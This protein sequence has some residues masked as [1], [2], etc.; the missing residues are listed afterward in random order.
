MFVFLVYNYNILFNIY[1]RIHILLCYKIIMFM[2]LVILYLILVPCPCNRETGDEVTRPRTKQ[3]TKLKT[4]VVTAAPTNDN[5]GL[6]DTNERPINSKNGQ[7]Q[8][9]G[10]DKRTKV[11]ETTATAHL[12]YQEHVDTKEPLMEE[13][14]EDIQLIPNP[15]AR[16]LLLERIDSKYFGNK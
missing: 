1:C 15:F 8:P 5:R 10:G 3:S 14:E 2:Y 6:G 11:D 16:D 9:E 7:L 4:A 12:D 13:E